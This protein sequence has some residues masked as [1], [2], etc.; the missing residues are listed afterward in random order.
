MTVTCF[1]MTILKLVTSSTGYAQQS[2]C[3]DSALQMCTAKNEKPMSQVHKPNPNP[4]HGPR[5]RDLANLLIAGDATLGVLRQTQCCESCIQP[6]PRQKC[7]FWVTAVSA[8]ALAAA[9]CP[10]CPRKKCLRDPPHTISTA[11]EAFCLFFFHSFLAT[12]CIVRPWDGAGARISSARC[13][14]MTPVIADLLC[15]TD[16]L[17]HIKAFSQQLFRVVNE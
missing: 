5:T 7:P 16:F 14:Q 3:R 2:W 15:N 4:G 11:Q 17:S 9:H 13:T 12:L 8:Q 1:A 6:H 10:A